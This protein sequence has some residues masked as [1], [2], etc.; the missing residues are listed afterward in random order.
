MA[1]Q[2]FRSEEFAV[3]VPACRTSAM[4]TLKR[5]AVKD[6]LKALAAELKLAMAHALEGLAA[7]LSDESPGLSNNRC[8][9]S[10][11][12]TFARDEAARLRLRTLL[13]EIKLTAPDALDVAPHHRHAHLAVVV[14][15]RGL[16]VSLRI[17]RRANVDRENLAARLRDA[18]A[19]DTFVALLKHL[20]AGFCFGLVDGRALPDTPVANASGEAMDQVVAHLHDAE[21]FAVTGLWRAEEAAGI[22]DGTQDAIV[23]RLRVLNDLYR[24][25]AWSPDNDHIAARK[26]IKEARVVEQ[27]Q[28]FKKGD[29]VRILAGLFGGQSGTVDDVDKKGVLRLRVGTVTVKVSAGDVAAQA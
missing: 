4:Y 6:K 13:E 21:W 24:F 11:W 29:K 2:G 23:E 17:H 12:L 8:V 9:D 19:R 14:D 1:A 18:F 28:G 26:A 7:E 27:Q 25:A 22:G 5:R 3:Y 16:E 10:Q 15:D 20:P